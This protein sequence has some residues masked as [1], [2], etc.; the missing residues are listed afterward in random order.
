MKKK[1]FWYVANYLQAL[2]MEHLSFHLPFLRIET[3]FWELKRFLEDGFCRREMLWSFQ[4]MR[5]IVTVQ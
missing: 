3:P 4:Q 1:A 2:T 5:F